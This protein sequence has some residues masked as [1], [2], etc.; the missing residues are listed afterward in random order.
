M[1]GK[2]ADMVVHS[3]EPYNAEPPRTALA[4]H[5]LTPADAFYVR[6]HGP[7][8]RIDPAS[9]RLD[10]DGLL[11]RPG[12]WSL[13]ELRDRFDEHRVTATLQCAGNRRA[14]LAEVREIPG[15]APWGP[16]ATGTAVWTGVLLADL[17]ADAGVDPAAT[18]V[19][20]SA[21]DVSAIPDPP[22][23]YR[24]SVPL[25]AVDRSEVLLARAMNGSPLPTVHGAP[26]RVVAPG[27]V[28][29]RSVK[30]VDRITVSDGPS[31]GF[32][33]AHSYRLLRPEEDPAAAGPGDGIALGAVALNS[34]ILAP[35]DGATVPAGTVRVDGYALAGGDRQ[36]VRV[37]V[38]TDGGATWL[39]ARLDEASGRWSWRLWTADLE[40]A[41]GGHQ[42]LARAW[43]D[44][45]AVQPRSPA[46]LWNPKGYANNSWARVTV[47]AR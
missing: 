18:H 3:E 19:V 43:D 4:G 1:R 24:A 25:E 11:E 36:V 2:R 45:A 46:E 23:P 40:L 12:T 35:A 10:L 17:L 20:F 44:S 41:P 7:V 6:N 29:A 9:Y 38:S 15:E 8:P 13:D 28:G 5:R 47:H 39:P 33:Q 30:W 32:F 34:D 27:R 31:D 22:E 42:L 37:D 26:L 21:P 16:A 14:G